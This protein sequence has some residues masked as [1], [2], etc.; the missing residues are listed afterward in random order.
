MAKFKELVAGDRPVLVDFYATWCGPCQ[1]MKPELERLANEVGPRARVIKIDVD[2]NRA[3][4][5]QYRIAS[6]PTVMLFQHG[7]PVWRQSG[8]MTARQL[9][10]M[11]GQFFPAD[12]PGWGTKD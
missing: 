4:A 12:F 9:K 7:K 10:T 2:K 6:I 8:A 5:E 3:V 11:L 1:Q